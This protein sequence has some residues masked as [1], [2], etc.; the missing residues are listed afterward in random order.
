MSKLFWEGFEKKAVHVT[1]LLKEIGA[2]N[3]LTRKN[4]ASQIHKGR[5]FL[6]EEMEGV[7]DK[8]HRRM[9]S[10]MQA[11]AKGP[12]GE[13]AVEFPVA[14]LPVNTTVFGK[15]NTRYPREEYR[16]AHG[17]KPAYERD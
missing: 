6:K 11:F 17:K 4:V 3:P 8:Y 10:T 2:N 15:N 7:A 14:G 13:G 12:K 5:G 16:K 1:K 9:G